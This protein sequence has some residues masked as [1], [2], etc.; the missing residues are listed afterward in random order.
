MA[1]E[2]LVPLVVKDLFMLES[3][4]SFM[5]K[6]DLPILLENSGL[7][8]LAGCVSKAYTKESAQQLNFL[9]S[10]ALH[11]ISQ[12]RYILDSPWPFWLVHRGAHL[13][14][15]WFGHRLLSLCSGLQCVLYVYTDCENKESCVF[16]GQSLC[17]EVCCNS[18]GEMNGQEKH[19]PKECLLPSRAQSQIKKNV[20]FY[21]CSS[22]PWSKK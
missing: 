9:D 17:F 13:F 1:P 15:L 5:T 8:M 14:G 4:K 16:K 11:C 7:L 21:V 22:A 2:V 18:N 10:P 12:R 3:N 6:Q 20:Y 19:L